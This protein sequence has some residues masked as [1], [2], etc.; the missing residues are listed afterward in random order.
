VW[1]FVIV[2]DEN[3]RSGARD[4]REIHQKIKIFYYIPD[5]QGLSSAP[6]PNSSDACNLNCG[7][8]K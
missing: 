5:W 2:S 4:P 1:E 3:E 8:G 6:G 7:I